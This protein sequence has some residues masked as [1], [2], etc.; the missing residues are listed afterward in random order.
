MNKIKQKIK[1]CTLAQALSIYCAIVTVFLL[2]H[3]VTFRQDLKLLEQLNYEI[4]AKILMISRFSAELRSVDANNYYVQQSI[5]HK[6]QLLEN[7]NKK[8]WMKLKEK[9]SE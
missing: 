6:I 3:F 2:Y 5:E 8:L 9:D 7:D 1:S 4:D